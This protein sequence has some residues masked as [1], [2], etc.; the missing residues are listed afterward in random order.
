MI[1]TGRLSVPVNA[2]MYKYAFLSSLVFVIGQQI[3]WPQQQQYFHL[4]I[5]F[6]YMA[7]GD[8]REHSRRDLGTDGALLIAVLAA[9]VVSIVER[10]VALDISLLYRLSLGVAGT[11]AIKAFL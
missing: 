6:A 2:S 9:S 3:Y 10:Y 7:F 5:L 11:V 8:L 4:A 1:S